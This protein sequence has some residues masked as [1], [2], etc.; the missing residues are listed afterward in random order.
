MLFVRGHA[1]RVLKCVRRNHLQY[2][3]NSVLRVTSSLWSLGKMEG[4]EEIRG[5]EGGTETEFHEIPSQGPSQT[6][7]VEYIR[8]PSQDYLI[9]LI[10]T[11]FSDSPSKYNYANQPAL[12]IL[13]KML[14]EDGRPLPVGSFTEGSVARRVYA[15][16]GLTVE[17][18]TMVT[19]TD[20]L[21]EFPQGT[22]VVAISPSNGPDSRMGGYASVGV[23]ADGK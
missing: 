5:A 23:R 14:R 8:A 7:Q 17:R 18:V 4:L 10:L 9:I 12:T 20:A 2:Y 11:V 13:F 1:R 21:V 15:I 19:P 16:T 22:L 3:P 6:S